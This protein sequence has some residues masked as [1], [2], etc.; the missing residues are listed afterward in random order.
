MLKDLCKD[1]YRAIRLY[2]ENMLTKWD[3]CVFW[4]VITANR[5]YLPANLLLGSDARKSIMVRSLL[6][7][8]GTL[9]G[10]K[11]LWSDEAKTERFQKQTLQVYLKQSVDLKYGGGS[12]LVMLACFSCTSS[13]ALVRI[14]ATLKSLKYQKEMKINKNLALLDFQGGFFSMRLYN[15]IKGWIYFNAFYAFVPVMPMNLE[16]VVYIIWLC[17]FHWTN[18]MILFLQTLHSLTSTHVSISLYW[19]IMGRM[20]SMLLCSTRSDLFPTRI[21]GTLGTLKQ[22]C[23]KPKQA[24]K[25]HGILKRASL[26]ISFF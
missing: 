25:K 23:Q 8:T 19:F 18:C 9:T 10:T 6:N 26:S 4:E 17:I 3:W 15:C 13:G 11:A 7:S 22:T 21:R 24:V 12:V 1:L 20:V 14:H 5:Y 2:R 16:D